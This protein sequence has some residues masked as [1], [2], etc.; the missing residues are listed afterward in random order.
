[1]ANVEDGLRFLSFAENNLLE[2]LANL[3]FAREA[4]PDLLHSE[5]ME[6]E[7]AEAAGDLAWTI[8]HLRKGEPADDSAGT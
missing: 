2:A 7:L 8:D 3:E 6:E 1:M 4:M 5:L